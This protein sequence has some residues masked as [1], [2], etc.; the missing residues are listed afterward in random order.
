VSALSR[1]Q[2]LEETAACDVPCA[3][4]A[5]AAITPTPCGA[6]VFEGGCLECGVGILYHTATT[7]ERERALCV[8]L[9]GPGASLARLTASRRSL[10][11]F[12]WLSRRG[13]A[14]AAEPCEAYQRALIE[15]HNRRMAEKWAAHWQTVP[16]AELEAGA[17]LLESRLS[18]AELAAIIWPGGGGKPLPA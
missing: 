13:D 2:K 14:R 8:E 6:E 4:H 10:A 3:L 9:Y 15:E 1:L 7:T 18:D 11:G 5:L 17:E 16:L 12:I